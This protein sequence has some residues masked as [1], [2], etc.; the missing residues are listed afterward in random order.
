MEHLSEDN[1]RVPLPSRAIS[2]A[3]PLSVVHFGLP[4]PVEGEGSPHVAGSTVRERLTL[5]PHVFCCSERP[6]GKGPTCLRTTAR[7]LARR[8]PYQR[9]THCPLWTPDYLMQSKGRD[10]PQ[11]A[12]SKVKKMSSLPPHVFC[13]SRNPSGKGPTCLRTTA[14]CPARRGRYQWRTHCPSSTRGFPSPSKACP[15]RWASAPRCP[16]M[17]PPSQV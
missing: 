5:A 13:C 4:D 14:G 15:S 11:V 9:Q 10:N 7:C 17:C 2:A 6:S 1:G 8:G 3:K 12:S 16:S